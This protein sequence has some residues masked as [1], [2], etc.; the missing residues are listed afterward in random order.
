MD[1]DRSVKIGVLSSLVAA[2]IFL[3]LLDPL[4]TILGRIFLTLTGIASK[5]YLDRLYS[6][7]ATGMPDFGFYAVGTG[8]LILLFMIVALAVASR[9]AST[10]TSVGPPHARGSKA[11]VLLV[12]FLFFLFI[13]FLAD[14]WVRLRTVSTFQQHITVL[15]PAISDLEVKQLQ[16]DFASMKGK[17]DY[18][19][20]QMRI[21]NLARSSGI[22]L[23]ENKLYPGF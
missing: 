15:A 10:N 17:G 4:L 20:L 12:A 5:Q 3:Y 8:M 13:V 18:D 11:D 22:A 16:A 6:E 1:I 9:V 14:G 19:R 21:R 23:P 7:I 2:V